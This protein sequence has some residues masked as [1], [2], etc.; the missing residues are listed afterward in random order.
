[1]NDT[2]TRL[3]RT[4]HV[5]PGERCELRL[6]E[7]RI[8]ITKEAVGQEPTTV[9]FPVAE[10]RGATL[11]RPSRAQPGWLH[12][13]VV[14]GSPAPTSDLGAALDPYTLPITNRNVAAARRVVRLVTQHVQERGLPPE[15]PSDG[16][17]SS[18]SVI[19]TSTRMPSS[20]PPP[21][22]PPPGAPRAEPGGGRSG[23]DEGATAGGSDVPDDAPSA[24][25]ERRVDGDVHGPVDRST[26]ATGHGGAEPSLAAA[27][28]DLADLHEAGALTGE[29]FERAKAKVLGDS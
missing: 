14:G 18:T 21:S 6:D 27:L 13:A 3:E 15:L 1:M 25:A 9:S 5:V 16:I 12:V 20:T 10:V 2:T 17:R 22:I 19:V 7:G 8:T 24:A 26:A 28:R 23:A 29:E 11:E 4:S